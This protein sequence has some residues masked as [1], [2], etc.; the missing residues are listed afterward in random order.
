M[1]R[2]AIARINQ[3]IKC[4]K[5]TRCNHHM[6]GLCTLTIVCL[7]EHGWHQLYDTVILLHARSEKSVL[8]QT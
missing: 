5:Q 1:K 8:T 3:S 4:M 7:S 6:H 2:E